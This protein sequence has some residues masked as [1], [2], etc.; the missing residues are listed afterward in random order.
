[1]IDDRPLAEISYCEQYRYW[2]RRPALNRMPERGTALFCMLNPSTADATKDDK[3][4]KRCRN[5]SAAWGCAGIVVINLYALRSTDPTLLTKHPDPVGDMNDYHIVE[6]AKEM[7]D[8]IVGWGNDGDKARVDK[9]VA[10][11]RKHNIRMFCLGVNK[12]GS[13]RHPLYVKK[14]TKL[15]PWVPPEE[16]EQS[17]YFGE[18]MDKLR[19]SDAPMG[20]VQELK[21]SLKKDA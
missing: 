15:I 1:M 14:T 21:D 3:T 18:H 11:F 2:L 13:P 17:R 9:V 6:R 12:N 5:F 4:I 8:V 10:M 19:A 7:C 20:S 16:V